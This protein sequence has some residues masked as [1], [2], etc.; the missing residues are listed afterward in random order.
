MTQTCETCGRSWGDRAMFCGVCGALLD[1]PLPN[2][3]PDDDRPTWWRRPLVGGGLAIIALVGIVAAV[4]TLSI[5][6][7]DPVE[8][9]SIDVPDVDDLQAAP[10]N[11]RTRR[12]VEPPDVSCTSDDV[13]VDCVAWSRGLV[14]PMGT[15]Q[16]GRQTW[17]VMFGGRLLLIGN[18]EVEA[19]DATTGTRLW[20]RTG[21][22]EDSH[23]VGATDELLVLLGSE[24]S[25]LDL[26]TGETRWS[27]STF[28][29]HVFGAVAHDDVVYTGTDSDAAEWGVTARDPRDGAVRW[30]WPTEWSDVRLQRLDGERLLVAAAG[31]GMAVLDA[32]TGEERSRAEGLSDGWIIDV[33][34]D[35]LVTVLHPDV[36]PSEPNRAGDPGAVVTG[37][38]IVDG[39]V[40]WQRD[41]RSSEASFTPVAGVMIA[42]SSRHLT[43]LDAGTG[44]VVW[45]VG[46]TASERVAQPRLAGPWS[47]EPSGSADLGLV[48]TMDERGP[49]LRGRDVT[50]GETVWERELQARP[51]HAVM[52]GAITVVQT[53]S[54]IDLVSTATGQEHFHLDSPDLQV[55][56]VDPL[57]V[58]HPV[59]GYVT[60]LD[61]HAATDR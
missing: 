23:P 43:A 39:T 11:T 16:N 37:H 2:R 7:T 12:T 56:G 51:W 20:R 17:P 60:R 34:G 49:M 21:M 35:T 14:E 19:V 13:E 61:L 48:V 41:V 3:G 59:S 57:I 18:G 25:L 45:E 47:A 10:G 32:T 1:R 15:T 42:P 52:L 22:P 33:V 55:V 40:K 5:Q 31:E 28:G 50:T 54:G 24:T 9:T 26:D 30:T 29:R 46:T 44:E 53:N 36:D 27:V 4:P 58:F 6:R 8:D 38:D